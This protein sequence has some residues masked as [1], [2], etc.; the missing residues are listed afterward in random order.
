MTD[1]QIEAIIQRG[2]LAVGKSVLMPANA[3][4]GEER[5]HEL[6]RYVRTLGQ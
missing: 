6:R 5:I 4:L 1:E 3:D 2:G